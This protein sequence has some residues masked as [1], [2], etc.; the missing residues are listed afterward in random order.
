MRRPADV[1]QVGQELGVRY[2]AEGG[3]SRSGSMLK[4]NV[5][6]IS[7]ESGML[8]WSDRFDEPFTDI[9]GGQEMVLGRMRD[10]L[11]FSLV[12][13]E[14]SRRLRERGHGGPLDYSR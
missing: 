13:L 10:G 5:E 9:A 3:V 11:G 12:E 1:R 8:L 7:A 2:V 14:A 6:L 4:V